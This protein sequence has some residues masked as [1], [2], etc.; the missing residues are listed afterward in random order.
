M[1][2]K[3]TNLGG[4]AITL[5]AMMKELPPVKKVMLIPSFGEGFDL[6][7]EVVERSVGA[8]QQVFDFAVGLGKVDVTPTSEDDFEMA[9]ARSH[10][11]FTNWEFDEINDE[12]IK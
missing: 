2:L 6:Y 12:F 4:D 9:R 10:L 7:L 3:A 8:T 1:F 11:T 5:V